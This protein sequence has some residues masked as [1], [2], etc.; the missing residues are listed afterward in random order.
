MFDMHS[1]HFVDAAQVDARIDSLASF[2]SAGVTKMVLSSQHEPDASRSPDGWILDVLTFYAV[3]VYPDFFIP[4]VRGVELFLPG[5]VAQMEAWAAYG[6]EAF[7]ELFVHGYGAGLYSLDVLADICAVAADYC[8]PVSCHWEIGGVFPEERDKE[9]GALR[10]SSAEA[11]FLQLLDLLNRFPQTHLAE[12]VRVGDE[13]PP[14]KFILCHCGAGASQNNPGDGYVALGMRMDA[15]IGKYP[16][17]YFDIAGI[18]TD[19]V[20]SSDLA[21]VIFA[22][23]VAHPDRFVVGLDIQHDPSDFLGYPWLY[24]ELLDPLLSDSALTAVMN[25]NGPRILAEHYQ[26]GPRPSV[27][28]H[29]RGVPPYTLPWP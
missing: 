19:L 2:G 12:F 15:L 26:A 16:N 10:E 27:G 8:I 21:D 9:T 7:G 6:A 22:R 13:T 28:L 14:L 29:W 18:Y 17:V 4:S 25:G 5:S 24:S 1:H 20:A 23:M 11:N 3:S